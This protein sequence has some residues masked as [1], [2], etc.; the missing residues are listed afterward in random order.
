MRTSDLLYLSI[1]EIHHKIKNKEMCPSDLIDASFQ[2]MARSEK[3]VN[4]F[5][6]VD[7]ERTRHLAKQLDQKL[8]TAREHISPLFGLPYGIKDN[9]CTQGIPTTCASKALDGYLP[10]LDATIYR[11]LVEA[12]TV[13][14]GKCNMDEFGMGSTTENSAYLITTNPWNYNHVPGGS[15]GG[16]AAAVAAGEIFFQSVRIRAVQSDSQQPSAV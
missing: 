6:Y 1:A 11:R 5:L 15:S 12:N 16:S 14:V 7:E 4:A 10:P 2:Q 8:M 3:T 13:L 9:I